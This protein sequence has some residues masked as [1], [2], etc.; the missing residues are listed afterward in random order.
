MP[1]RPDLIVTFLAVLA[2]LV[3]AVHILLDVTEHAELHTKIDQCMAD[4][5]VIALDHK[6]SGLSSYRDSFTQ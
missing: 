5:G 4:I 2:C 6:R 3:S 1:R